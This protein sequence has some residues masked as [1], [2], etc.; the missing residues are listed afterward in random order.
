MK[1]ILILAI[2]IATPALCASGTLFLTKDEALK[3]YFP[4]AQIERKT[5]Y[6]TPE[7]KE[8]IKQKARA[9]MESRVVTYYTAR[10]NNAVIG[11]AFF[12]TITVRTKEASYMVA[13]NPN[14]SVRGVE[15]LTFYEPADYKPIDRWFDQFTNHSLQNDLMLR[16]GIKNIA[17]AT[18]SAQ[19]FSD[20]VR[21]ILAI[22]SLIVA[23]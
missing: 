7:Q 4:D 8:T 22:Y 10:K 3:Q 2:V 11:Y 19:G 1:F 21:R 17:G 16:S 23:K 6:L 18:L 14:G 13:V 12:E 15:I 5:E 9:P 20:G